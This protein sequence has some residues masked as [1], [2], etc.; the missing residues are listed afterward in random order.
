MQAIGHC[1]GGTYV[2]DPHVGLPRH[3]VAAAAAP[4]AALLLLLLLMQGR[5]RP[6]AQE[7]PRPP[8]QRGRGGG[9]LHLV[10]VECSWG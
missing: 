4:T 10:C 8:W 5:P 2:H 1:W 7:E 3:D 6:A 9:C